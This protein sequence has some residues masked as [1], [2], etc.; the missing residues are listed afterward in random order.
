MKWKFTFR[1]KHLLML[2]LI[3]LLGNASY[4]QGPLSGI[5]TIGSTPGYSTLTAAVDSLTA[6]GVSGPVTFNLLAATYNEQLAITAIAGVSATNTVTFK[7]LGDATKISYSPL[8]TNL[9]VIGLN[10]TKHFVF[11]SLYVEVLGAQG[12]GFNFR[13]QSDSNTVRNCHITLPGVA[14]EHKGICALA[15]INGSSTTGLNANYLLIENN[16]I[17][18]GSHA[19]SVLGGTPY[20]IGN[21]MIGNTIINYGGIGLNVTGNAQMDVIGNTIN[22]SVSTVDRAIN[23]WP[24]GSFVNVIGNS[25]YVNSNAANTRLIQVA[26]APGGGVAGEPIIIAN[27]MIIYAGSASANASCIYTKNTSYMYIYNNTTMISSGAGSTCIWL[28]AT[29]ADNNVEVKNNNIAS[30]V[31]G[32][33][34]LRKHPSITA[35]S[36]NNNLY[37]PYYFSVYWSTGYASLSTFQAGTGDTTSV[38]IDPLFVSNTNLHILP[39]NA[40]FNGLGTPI[41]GITH[42][43]DGDL[44]NALTPDIGADEFDVLANDAGITAIDGVFGVCAGAANVY[45]TLANGGIAPLTSATLKWEV[46]GVLQSPVVFS[47][48]IL[49]GSTTSV[50]L[51]STNLVSGVLYDIKVWSS[52]PNNQ[53]DQF[54]LNDTILATG[55]QT[56]LAGTYSI[57]ATGNYTTFNAAVNAL[58][59]YGVCAPVVFE[60]APGTY[61]E[62]VVLPTIAGVS[63]TNTITFTSQTGDSTSVN[64]EWD[65]SSGLMIFTLDQSDYVTIKK[66][67]IRSTATGND[68]QIIRLYSSSHINI[69]NNILQAPSLTASGTSSVIVCESGLSSDVLIANN[70]LL[71][72]NNAIYYTGSSTTL[73]E[74]VIIENNIIDGFFSHAIYATWHKNL[75]FRNNYVHNGQ[76]VANPLYA[77]EITNCNEGQKLLGNTININANV[78]VQG[79][80]YITVPAIS[81]NPNLIANNFVSVSG[82]N[83]DNYG[84]VLS[85][86]SNT[87]VYSNSVNIYG[88]SNT[89]GAYVNMAAAGG[90]GNIRLTNNS[91][92]NTAGGRAFYCPNDAMSPGQIVYQDY[93]NYYSNGAVSVQF[94]VWNVS[95]LA[96][97]NLIEPHSKLLNPVYASPTD[98]HCYSPF[99]MT[100]GKPLAS[101]LVDIDGETRNLLHPSIGADEFTLFTVDAGMSGFVGLGIIC[102][103]TTDIFA[104][105]NNFGLLPL[106]SVTVD[107]SVNGVAQQTVVVTD[108][109]P[110]GGSID[111]NLGT[112]TIVAGS[113][114]DFVGSTS[115]PNGIADPN[116]VNDGAS[117]LG[118]QP[119]AVGSYTIGA[120]GDFS[121]IAAAQQFI[122]IYGLCGA[123]VFNILPGTYTEQVSLVEVPGVSAT[124]TVTWQSSTGINTDVTF[125]YAA[126]GTANNWVWAFDGA[127]HNIVQNITIKSTTA[128]T[129]GRVVIF[130]NTSNYNTVNGNIIEGIV[131]TSTNAATIRSYNDSKDEFNIIS[132]NAITGGY[133]GIYWYGSSSDL[134][135]GNQFLNNTVEMYYYYGLYNTYQNTNIAIGN[136]IYQNPGGSTTN[137]PLYMYYCDGPIVVTNNTV[138]DDAGSTFYGI[139]LYYCDASATARSLVANN[140]VYNDGVT[141]TSYGMRLY[142]SSFVNVYHN[143]V[144]INTGSTTYGIYTYGGSNNPG[145]YDFKNNNIVNKSG[146]QAIYI[147]NLLMNITSDHNNYYTTG[148]VL[149]YQGGNFGN[150]AAWQAN[151]PNDLVSMDGSYLANNNLHSNAID[152]DGAGVPVSEITT[153]IDGEVRDPST[154][155]IGAD[156]F[157][158]ANND[159]AITALPGINAYCPGV[160]DIVAT[161]NN[162]GLINMNSVVVNWMVN[163]VL[164]TPF[165][166]TTTIPIGTSADVVIGT[167]N[168][169]AGTTYDFTVWS[170]L[171]N[172]SN[173]PNFGN[174]SIIVTGVTTAVSGT[175]TIGTTGDFATFNDAVNLL[176]TNGMCGPVVFNVQSGTYEENVSVPTILGASA[177]NT[178]TFQSVTGVNTDVTLQYNPSGTSDNYVF[179]LD[180]ADYVTV[181]NMKIRAY[182]SGNYGYAVVLQS[183]ADYN[184][185]SNCVIYSKSNTS[186][187]S[188]CV[189][190]TSTSSENY[191]TFIGN[192]VRYGYYGF[193]LYASSGSPEMGNQIIDNYI[194]EY[195]YYGIY[196][197]YNYDVTADGNYCYQRPAGST[198]NYGI[199]IY[200]G[201]G[202]TSVVNNTVFDDAGSTFYGIRMSYC[203]PTSSGSA[204]VANNMVS[205]NG[206]T[207]SVYS[208]YLY[209]ST[210]LKC[211]NNSVGIYSGG[212]TYGIY[213]YGSTTYTGPYD[214]KNNCV[215]NYDGLRAFYCNNT[216]VNFTSDHNNWYSTGSSEVYYGAA[217]TTFAQWQASFPG[218]VLNIDP[219]FLAADNLHTASIYMNAAGTPVPEVTTDIDGDIRNTTSPDIG[220][221][222]FNLALPPV[223]LALTLLYHLGEVPLAGA[224]DVVSVTVQN[225]GNDNQYNYPVIL[226]ITGANTFVDTAF[227]PYI[228]TGGYVTV[229]FA[230][231][232]PTSIGLNN[233]AV[234]VPNDGDNTNNLLTGYNHATLNRVSYADT[235]AMAGTGGNNDANGHIYWNKQYMNGIKA[236]GAIQ[237]YISDDL[238]NVGNTV[239][240]AVMDANFS[241]LV[242]SNPYVLDTTDLSSYITL[243]FA[244]PSLTLFLNAEY[245]AG[246]AQTTPIGANYS[247]I[248]YQDEIPMRPGTYFSSSNINGSGFT[249]YT[250]DRRWMIKAI[251]NDPAP[252]DAACIAISAPIGGCGLG[253]ETVSIRIQNYGMNAIAGSLSAY[254]QV[255]NGT[256]VSQAVTAGIAVGD[257]LDFN[258][259]TLADFTSSADSIFD[260]TAWVSLTGDLNQNNDT[261]FS[262]VESLYQPPVPIA[263]NPTVLYGS[264]A[265]LSVISA[266]AISWYEDSLMTTPVGTGNDLTIGPLYDTATYY[267]QASS[268]GGGGLAITEFDIGANDR[269]EIQ[270]LT[271]S[272]LNAMGWIVAVSNSYTN[273]N[274]INSIYWDLGVFAAGETMFR[275][276]NSGNTTN[277]WGINILWDPNQKGWAMIIDGQGEI[278]DMVIWGWTA[279]DIAV[280]N[281]IINTFTVDPSSAWNGD[282][283]SSYSLAFLNRVNYDNNDATDWISSG[284]ANMGSANVGMNISSS[285]TF[286]ESAIVPVTAFVANI[287]NYDIGVIAAYTPVSGTNLS[288]AETVS[289]E[290]NNWG[291]L[292][293]NLFQITYDISGATSSSISELVALTTPIASGTSAT[294]TFNTPVDLSAYGTYNI[295]V[296]TQLT[297]DGF[298]SN[299]TLC[300]SVENSAPVYCVSSATNG[301]NEEIVQV[302]LSNISNYSFPS[303]AMYSNYNNSVAPGILVQGNAHQISITSDYAPGATTLHDCWVEVYIDWDNDGIYTEPQEIA[304]GSAIT[305]SQTVSG[306]VTVPITAAYGNHSMRVVM[307]QIPAASG[308]VP[309]GTYTYGETEDYQVFVQPPY[310]IDAGAITILSPNGTLLENNSYPVEVVVY[311]Y[312]T[313]TITSM[314]VVYTVNGLNPVTLAYTGVLPSFTS[315]TVSFG[316]LIV[317]GGYFE[318]CAYTILANDGST[319][320]DAT[321]ATLFADPQYDLEMVSIDAPLGGCGLGLENVTVTFVNLADTVFGNLPVSFYEPGMTAP[322]TETYTGTLLPGDTVNYTFT[323]QIDLTVTIQTEMTVSAWLSFVGDP[324]PGNDTASLSILSDVSPAAPLANDITIWAGTSGILNVLN[325]DSTLFYEWFDSNNMSLSEE[326]FYETPILF[327]TTTYYLQASNGSLEP[328]DLFTTMVSG[329]GSTGNMFDITAYTELTIDSFYV[330][331]DGAS[332]M[333]VWY[334]EGSYLGFQSNS[335]AWTL[336]GSNNVVFAGMNNN[337]LLA[338]GGITIPAG[339]TY[340]IY[341]AITS[342]STINYTNGNGTNE[343][344]QNND[345]QI[346]CGAGGSYFSVTI[347]SRVWNG[348]VFYTAGAAGCGS[349]LTPVNANVQYANYDG[350]VLDITSPV[351]AS[352][353][354]N[355]A[356]T[357][358]VYNNGLLSFSNFNVQ[359]TLNGGTPVT[360]LV[361]TTVAPGQVYSFT[362]TDSVPASVFGTYNICAKIILVGDG[363]AA[364]DQFC[365]TFTN[366][367]GNGESCATAFPYLV[368]N[369]P[370]VYQTTMHPYDRQWWRFE[371]PVDATNVD[372]SLCGSSFDTKLE[373]HNEC[374]AS[375][376]LLS[377]FLGAN[378]NSC[379]QQSLVHFNAL[380]AGTYYARVFGYQ[381]EFGNYVLEITGTFADIA[382]VNF[383]VGNV[384]CNGAANGSVV[385]SVTPIIPGG[386]LPFTYLWSNQSTNLNLSNLAPGTYTLTITDAMGIPQIETVTITE[387][388]AM[389]L[390]LASTDVTSI[391]ANDGA[392]TT[393]VNGGV[394]PYTFAWSNGATTQNI[395]AAYAGVYALTVWDANNCILEDDITINSPLPT[396][397]TVTPTA[398]SHLII[399]SQNSNITL[400][401]LNAAYGSLIGVFYNQNGTMVCAGWAYWSGMSTSI[402]AYGAVA[403]LDNGYQPGEAFVW[404][405]YEASL[406]V[407]YSGPACYLSGYPNQGTYATGG[408][409]GINCLHAQSIITHAINLPLGW[410]IWSTYVTP[411]NANMATIFSSITSS[412]TIVKSGSGLIYW[413]LYSLNTIGNAVMGQGYQIKMGAAQ[414]LNVQGLLIN[415]VVSPFNIPGGWSIMGYLRTS[416]MNAVTVMSPIVSQ[417]IIVKSGGGQIYWPLY[418]LNTIGNMVPGQGYQIKMLSLQSFTFPANTAAPTK[419]E[420]IPVQPEKYNKVNN[421]GHNMSLGI[422]EDAWDVAPQEGDEIGV[423]N[424][425]GD[426]IGGS[427]YQNGFNAITVW[428][429]D[430][431]TE[432]TTEGIVNGDVFTLKLWSYSTGTEQELIVKSWLQGNDQ[433]AKDAISVIE[434]L[435]VVG[436]DY[437]GFR[438]YQNVPNPFKDVTEISFNL[439]EASHVRLVVYNALGEMIEE[440]VSARYDAGKYSVQFKTGNLSSGTYFYKIVSDKFTDTKVMNIQ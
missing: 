137:Y 92:A 329:N 361:N 351:S 286:C 362:F 387:P 204:L 368:I 348:T 355:A 42:D 281:P 108:T 279:A 155:D 153:D 35:V 275:T 176:V 330:N 359:Y 122:Q 143:S 31:N 173:D 316:N 132:N 418:N 435:V 293:A 149:A 2:L 86:V 140:M 383:T 121:S 242:L 356:V 433:Y 223:D 12:W 406:G 189:Y 284:T 213:L 112:Y 344:Y 379:G 210:D 249:A 276:D 47:G 277:Y 199:Y 374:P 104:T 134:E 28:D 200:Y 350:A 357:I 256:V 18:G 43:I 390:S 184:T 389:S 380:S 131:T 221:D 214:V 156:E 254:Y 429:D 253:M 115:M 255:N 136:Y 126:T 376:F 243:T 430:S 128:S 236:V 381:G 85:N 135:E 179:M 166:Y 62:Q 218:D 326:T 328:G 364:N 413:P 342:G 247:P 340:G 111:V 365:T 116:T 46:N 424:A 394:S 228:P 331:V 311:N 113:I 288:N 421:T 409:S 202:A 377:S 118:V 196:T 21:K 309:C 114:Y 278:V 280:W 27:N 334:K 425:K 70:K 393:T 142:A 20:L 162:Y 195:Y 125:Q 431:Y 283:I 319:L 61:T 44:R 16:L 258:F 148:S 386:T 96:D 269:I 299:D 402:T 37:N 101:V 245:Y 414:T 75:I 297:G 133:Y 382:I 345:M 8:S 24:T 171:P 233:I 366:W 388:P 407:E 235:T 165:S 49:T 39:S 147:S 185:I 251:L 123:V 22:S 367:D 440:L 296:Y 169:L 212:T 77:V 55:I 56:A 287:P 94:G 194:H 266:D 285:L 323:A 144:N 154:P 332:V 426:L 408:F 93:N 33:E 225:V 302:N 145:P 150:I 436:E 290:I 25:V 219:E 239:Y 209:Y 102:P 103:G 385:P 167:Y 54:P 17:E 15:S 306:L 107:W 203:D 272:T 9:P 19:I 396:G 241:Q 337:S 59:T 186:S 270:N 178:I 177:V 264:M 289:V 83:G 308:V 124:N 333:E 246:F 317:P 349:T 190:S 45:A 76:S 58:L 187:S 14:T 5:Y 151:Y 300:Y 295:C 211:Y 105:I 315:D 81:S 238:N 217:L 226:N 343:I 183:G 320:N 412:V 400:D 50:L 110:V 405:L 419:S 232:T 325:P 417:I 146:G 164:Q 191:N 201:D 100:A 192:E 182:G 68:G 158:L 392:I 268:S 64:L 267:A 261:V 216:A 188:A 97:L 271:N 250:N 168:L 427:V 127:D 79:I 106:T 363:Y 180:G 301:G 48:S 161:V 11:D 4:S 34:L 252:W 354:N 401:G 298:S 234:S 163:G 360:Q 304:F 26:N 347:A 207:G 292:P 1:L 369:D 375:S 240:G 416:P 10:A 428:G 370:P 231:F 29:G 358:D 371:V 313:N 395:A 338:I 439:P 3:S 6:N 432:N 341:V 260:I 378:D 38:S 57:G 327:D 30:Y 159:A 23:S 244:D 352:N 274:S 227:V 312:G 257:T 170:T 67:T 53:P 109:I 197:Y 71:N 373:V 346:E 391:G 152:L 237:A 291:T 403:P 36:S 91:F 322:V 397:W 294:F 82:G 52:Q 60:I 305:S 248:G 310:A 198:T 220:A 438:L 420:A 139:Y 372:V 224:S 73:N 13:N 40:A 262:T 314:D 7:G 336:A 120:T 422:L 415:P 65:T 307:E 411:V 437:N 205:C 172:N 157:T 321:C 206:V 318:L 87:N 95:N 129:Y 141:G 410:S 69:L 98:L 174:D 303:G 324:I 117:N 259:T 74:N 265:T 263:V 404:R 384:L 63:A 399:V 90:Y 41:S 181:Q 398:N 88:G 51:G 130:Q 230:P 353:M 89:I 78:V 208:M 119:A 423:F 339:E 229:N 84:I 80:R 434:K 215:A 72:S 99:L 32:A 160:S 282:G 222:E 175:Y 138:A 335:S 193:Y 273:I 66:I